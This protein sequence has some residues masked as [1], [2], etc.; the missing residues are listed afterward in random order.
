MDDVEWLEGPNPRGGGRDEMR[1]ERRDGRRRI[2]VSSELQYNAVDGIKESAQ[3]TV[4]LY[5][6]FVLL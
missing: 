6:R 1:S 3:C 4:Y 5:V 2:K